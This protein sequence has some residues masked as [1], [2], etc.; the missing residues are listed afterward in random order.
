MRQIEVRRYF[1]A[2][3][4]SAYWSK[5]VSIYASRSHKAH[6][7]WMNQ[8]AK[9]KSAI[10][11]RKRTTRAYYLALRNKKAALAQ[12][13]SRRSADLSALKVAKA[14]YRRNIAAHAAHVRKATAAYRVAYL[15]FRRSNHAIRRARALVKRYAL[16][17][18]RTESAHQ[19]IIKKFEAFRSSLLRSR[20]AALRTHAKF[21]KLAMSH[22]HS[23]NF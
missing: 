21:V 13:K 14:D 9:V 1:A 2:R 12:A 20:A 3:N 10:A 17:A 7:K 4:R 18:K 16:I 11:M 15:A 19:R 23:G 6:M 8:Q 5:R 22:Y